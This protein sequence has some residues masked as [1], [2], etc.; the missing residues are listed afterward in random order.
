VIDPAAPGHAVLSQ[1]FTEHLH[2]LGPADPTPFDQAAE[3]PHIPDYRFAPSGCARGSM[4]LCIDRLH[5]CQ[6]CRLRCRSLRSGPSPVVEG[7]LLDFAFG[8]SVILDTAS[9]RFP[10][11]M[12][13][14]APEG[15]TEVLA[16]GVAGI[17]EKANPAMSALAPQTAQVG[18]GLQVRFQQPKILFH[19]T[20]DRLPAVPIRTELKILRDLYCKKPKLWL[21]IQRLII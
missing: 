5:R 1:N 6:W 18:P 2:H 12:G 8:L 7:T 4:A 20:R 10:F 11:A 3:H 14:P 15:A 9:R 21:K 17:G 16:P 13:L 19:Q